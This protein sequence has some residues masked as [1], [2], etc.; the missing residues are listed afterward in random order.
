M[1]GF[2]PRRNLLSIIRGRTDVKT[3]YPMSRRHPP[4]QRS[5]Q[6]LIRTSSLCVRL[7]LPPSPLSAQ[8]CPHPHIRGAPKTDRLSSHP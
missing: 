4:H 5:D 8:L 7:T 6:R 1:P 2:L 3:V